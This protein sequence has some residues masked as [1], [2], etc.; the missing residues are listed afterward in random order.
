MLLISTQ[1]IAETSGWQWQVTPWLWGAGMKGDVGAF[2]GVPALHVDKSFDDILKE[3]RFSGFVEFSAQRDRFI[4]DTELMYIRTKE[5]SSGNGEKLTLRTNQLIGTIAPGYRIAD[6]PSY[7][8]DL[9]LG[10]RY[11]D[12]NNSLSLHSAKVTGRYEEGISW[13]DG[14]AGLRG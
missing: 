13:W 1:A 10:V 9:L 2:R 6:D 4:V 8:L 7:S 14:M 11:W 3:T 5:A 12:I